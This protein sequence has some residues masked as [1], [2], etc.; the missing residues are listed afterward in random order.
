MSVIPGHPFELGAGWDP[1]FDGYV[2]AVDWP[3]SMFK[4]HWLSSWALRL[5]TA[6]QW[7][8]GMLL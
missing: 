5:L 3:A 7:R 1:L 6:I 2:A 8:V 4:E